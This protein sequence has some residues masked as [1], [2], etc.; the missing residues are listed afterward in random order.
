MTEIACQHR[1]TSLR[2]WVSMIGEL[3]KVRIA[4][5]VTLSVATGFLVFSERLSLEILLP[6]AGTFLL[7]CGSAVLNQVQEARI[8]ALMPRTE[9]RPIP[10]GRVTRQWAIALTIGLVGSGFTLLA[11][12]ERHTLTVLALGLLALFWYNGVYVLLKRVTPFAV[13]PGSL[14]GAIPP[15]I[16]WVS[17]GGMVS[18]PTILALAV[19]F[20]LWQ[21]PHFWLLLILYGSEYEQAGLPSLTATFSSIQLGRITT[22]WIVAVATAGVLLGTASSSHLPWNGLIVLSSIWLSFNAMFLIRVKRIENLAFRAFMQINVYVLLIMA[23]LVGNAF[24]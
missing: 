3:T 2:A 15:V 8:D 21:I 18:D 23:F 11:S 10:S 20:F 1:D 16:G 4:L 14:I 5:V 7:A 13:V 6:L 19:F 17:A 9:R 12:V 24:Y 22:V